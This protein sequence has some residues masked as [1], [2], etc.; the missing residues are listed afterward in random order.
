[1]AGEDLVAGLGR[2]QRALLQQAHDRARHGDAVALQDGDRLGAAG[3]IRH[4]GAACDDRWVVARHVADGERDDFRRRAG[5]GQPPAL[6]AR[7]V[8]AHAVHLGDVGAR[9]QQLLVD[10]LLVFQSEAF[11]RQREQRRAAAR[12]QAQHEVVLCQSMRHRQDALGRFQP[13]RIRHR[14]CCFDDLDAA[15]EPI[16]AR[17]DVVIAGDDQPFKR[18]IRGPQGFDGLCHGAACLA[19]AQHDGAALGGRRQES[20]R[21]VQRQGAFD[22]AMVE[23]LEEAARVG[24]GVGCHAGGLRPRL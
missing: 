6:D 22:G 9:V 19:R 16:R 20:G 1:M 5:R 4:G 10:A 3:R 15:L 13:G 8:L 21:V 17:R 24:G 18:R 23:V 14:M 12:D 11:G 2:F 7:Q